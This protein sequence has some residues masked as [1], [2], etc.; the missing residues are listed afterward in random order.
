MTS[1]TKVVIMLVVAVALLGVTTLIS[2]SNKVGLLKNNYPVFLMSAHY[3]HRFPSLQSQRQGAEIHFLK[4]KGL[5][6]R[7]LVIS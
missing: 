6:V 4:M 5:E 1:N 7:V 3:S 2:I